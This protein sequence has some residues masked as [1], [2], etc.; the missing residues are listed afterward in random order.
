MDSTSEE[1][2]R[3]GKNTILSFQMADLQ[4]R[5]GFFYV[6]FEGNTKNICKYFGVDNLFIVNMLID[7]REQNSSL[8]L[9]LLIT[10]Y[11]SIALIIVSLQSENQTKGVYNEENF[12]T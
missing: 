12:E 5:F 10:F 9:W 3:I 8:I 11:S 2:T 1:K 6:H 4:P 7:I